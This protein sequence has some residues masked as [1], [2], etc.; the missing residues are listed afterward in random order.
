M[1]ED[2]KLAVQTFNEGFGRNR[3]GATMEIPDG[4]EVRMGVQYGMGGD[5]HL[6]ADLF[7]P[8]AS[9]EQPRPAMLFIHGGGWQGGTAAQFYRQAAMLAARGIVGA[10]CRYRFSSE[11]TFPASVY[12]VKAAVRWLRADAAALDIDTD[13]IGATGGSAG[14]HLAA[15]L[16]T[17]AGVEELEGDGGS[18]GYSSAVQLGVLLNPVTDMTEFVAE[19][20]LHPAAVRYLGGTPEEMQARYELASPIR[21]IDTSTPPCLLLHGT[22]DAT[23]PFTQSTRFAAALKDRGAR[24]ELILVE[25]VSHGFFNGSPYFEQTWPAIECFVLD[26]FGM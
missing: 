4:V 23:V 13:R 17:T 2:A 1:T 24:A 15:M 11:A 19:T 12:D 14:G 18:E 3:G 26:V 8:P 6:T 21:F 25:G 20:N 9:F 10:C 7:L 22:A 5:T 16:A